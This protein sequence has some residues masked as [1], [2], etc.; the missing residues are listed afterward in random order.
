MLPMLLE[1][2]V[3]IYPFK[4]RPTTLHLGVSCIPLA[5]KTQQQLSTYGL[6]VSTFRHETC[7]SNVK[8]GQL[9]I[10]VMC[11]SFMLAKA[12]AGRVCSKRGSRQCTAATAAGSR[13]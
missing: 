11:S 4:H 10:V 8:S 7:R 3:C 1:Q 6:T 12:R 5:V 9:K 2:A 13:T